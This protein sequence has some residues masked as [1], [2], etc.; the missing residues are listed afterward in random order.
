MGGAVGECEQWV[1][2]VLNYSSQYGTISYAAVK[3]VGAPTVYPDYK[4]SQ[5][6]PA[7]A[8]T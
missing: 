2:A 6:G 3:V 1:E 4:D 8:I 5:V 7:T